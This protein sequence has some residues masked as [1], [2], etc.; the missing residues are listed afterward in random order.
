MK[1]ELTNL[2]AIW[3]KLISHLSELG[4]DSIVISEDFYWEI[5]A[6]ERYD[7]YAQSPEKVIGQLTEDW[8]TLRQVLVGKK[9]P[10]VD[11]FIKLAAILRSV[12]EIGEASF[13]KQK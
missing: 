11:D 5:M 13:L 4:V 9:D 3:D 8:N 7:V 2:I 6:P 10:I 12:G 1:I